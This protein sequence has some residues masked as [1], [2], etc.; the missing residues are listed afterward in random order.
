MLVHELW[1]GILKAIDEI[2]PSSPARLHLSRELKK[3]LPELT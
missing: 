1:E 2:D 3:T